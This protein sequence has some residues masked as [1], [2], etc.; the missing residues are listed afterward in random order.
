MNRTIVERTDE[1]ILNIVCGG[2]EWNWANADRFN[3]WDD[4]C[5]NLQGAMLGMIGSGRPDA[6]EDFKFLRD[7]ARTRKNMRK[8]ENES[9]GE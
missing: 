8:E 2:L 5:G 4:L 3:I 1:E 7:L 9:R 6:E